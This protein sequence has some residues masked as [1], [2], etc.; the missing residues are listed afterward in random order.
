MNKFLFLITFF[1]LGVILFAQSPIKEPT[2]R[3]P[4]LVDSMLKEVLP[5]KIKYEGH[6]R[7]T[8]EPARKTH[9]VYTVEIPTGFVLEFEPIPGGGKT[10]SRF[11]G[12]KTIEDFEKGI[13]YDVKEVRR[14]KYWGEWD[15]LKISDSIT[16]VSLA[17]VPISRW[18][19]GP[20]WLIEYED[21]EYYISYYPNGNFKSSNIP[22][23]ISKKILGKIDKENLEEYL[24]TYFE[25]Y[26]D[27][28]TWN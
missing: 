4:I 17:E 21:K 1:I 7:L 6:L 16:V 26:L 15:Y 9:E 3:E 2:S 13:I 23:I 24:E 11:E 27:I 20:Y 19:R 8:I 12:V 28:Y 10:W 22:Q 18:S 14:N 25:R 5:I